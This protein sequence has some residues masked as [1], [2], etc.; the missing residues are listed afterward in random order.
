MGHTNPPINIYM[1]IIQITYIQ[2][3]Q[4]R[5]HPDHANHAFIPITQ[6]KFLLMYTRVK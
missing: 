5:G 6:M 1:Q 4:V 2:L 3:S